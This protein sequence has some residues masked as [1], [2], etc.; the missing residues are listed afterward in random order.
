MN[1]TKN[2]L[3]CLYHRKTRNFVIS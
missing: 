3:K 2:N 1:K